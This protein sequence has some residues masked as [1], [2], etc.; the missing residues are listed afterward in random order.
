[1]SGGIACIV[2][3]GALALLLPRYRRYDAAEPAP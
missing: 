1:V 3:A 2:G